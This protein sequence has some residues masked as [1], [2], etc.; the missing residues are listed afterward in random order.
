M[1]FLVYHTHSKMKRGFSPV[2]KLHHRLQRKDGLSKIGG[3]KTKNGR[4]KNF[5]LLLLCEA[6]CADSQSRGGTQ[7]Y[8]P[9]K[10]RVEPCVGE[11]S[12]RSNPSKPPPLRKIWRVDF[13]AGKRAGVAQHLPLITHRPAM[14]VRTTG[15]EVLDRGSERGY[16]FGCGGQVCPRIAG[17]VCRYRIFRGSRRGYTVLRTLLT[18]LRGRGNV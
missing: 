17:T 18:F 1:G 10:H 4:G 6:L 12:Q 7:Y 5:T 15:S 16:I 8:P 13:G 11:I 9:Q 14:R 3:E 2:Y